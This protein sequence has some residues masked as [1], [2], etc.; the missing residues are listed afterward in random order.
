MVLNSCFWKLIA[1][2]GTM[3]NMKKYGTDDAHALGLSYHEIGNQLTG[4][5]NRDAILPFNASILL[6]SH[7][8]NLTHLTLILNIMLNLT[9]LLQS[10]LSISVNIGIHIQH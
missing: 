6:F 9:S 3:E 10:I 8:Y 2:S 7:V 5:K 1:G 4:E